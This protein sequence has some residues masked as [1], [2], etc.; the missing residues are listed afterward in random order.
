[1]SIKIFFNNF[2]K[3]IL[4]FIL[5]LCNSVSANENFGLPAY[6]GED[7]MNIIKK[8]FQIKTIK[9]KINKSKKWYK[10]FIQILTS[11]EMNIDKKYKK[12]FLSKVTIE[13]NIGKKCVFSA[14]IRQ[15]GDWKD[16]VQYKSEDG[17][18]TIVQSVNVSLLN[19]HL[20]GITNFKLFAPNTR[21][22]IGEVFVTNLLR[23]LGYIA[24]RSYMVDVILNDQKKIKML[25]QE[26]MEK[27][28]LEFHN[29]REGPILEGDE[30]FIWKKVMMEKKN[31]LLWADHIIL[32]RVT[33]SQFSMKNNASKM[34]SLKAL[35]LL[36]K[37]YFKNSYKKKD[38]EKEYYI[39]NSYLAGGNKN[40]KKNLDA[41]DAILLSAFGRHALKP[42]NRI[43]YW[44]TFGNYF[45]PIY[46]DGNLRFKETNYILDENRKEGVSIAKLMIKQLDTKA[47]T[48]KIQKSNADII[49]QDIKNYINRISSNLENIKY[50]NEANEYVFNIDNYLKNIELINAQKINEEI[51]IAFYSLKKNGIYTCNINAKYNCN[52]QTITDE[53]FKRLLSGRYIKDNKL[54]QFIGIGEFFNNQ[55]IINYED[56]YNKI[57]KVK[58]IN[59]STI[60]YTN[61][62]NIDYD[63][64]KEL[65]ILKYKRG[66]H[67]IFNGGKLKDLN[68]KFNVQNLDSSTSS[69]DNNMPLTGCITFYKNEINKLKIEIDNSDCEDGVNFVNVVGK[70]TSINVNNSLSDGIDFDFSNLSVDKINI[71][72]AINDCVDFSYGNYEIKNIMAIECGD[73]AV[74]IGENSKANIEDLQVS[75]TN[76]ALAVKDSSTAN[77]QNLNTIKV[78]SCIKS[79]R[80]K[81]EF[82]GAIVN[83]HKFNCENANNIKD[84]G[85]HINVIN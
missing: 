25:L 55:I 46:Y 7:N 13:N 82:S 77:I 21:N 30:R 48:K 70:I 19:D 64:K 59:N 23:E 67:L 57:Y 79:Y 83:I 4:L 2:R 68:I 11:K 84:K 72:N 74:S 56:D 32:S 85:S 42:H 36:N 76:T 54:V 5:L 75:S 47:L 16:H 81:N 29:R 62:I 28:L 41:Y 51:I 10:N 52:F 73:K 20:N 49:E 33:N 3:I 58:K 9:I 15:N 45:E 18:V 39:S 44:N 71:K 12:N 66:G 26:S 40:Y 65:N 14:K 1:M 38:N 63:G 60:Y 17:K 69:I 50:E 34:S 61:G 24:P 43:F 22:F 6:C 27:E 31:K 35:S 80:K 37:F 78:K 8:E 53:G